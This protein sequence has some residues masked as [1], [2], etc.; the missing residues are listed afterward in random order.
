MAESITVSMPEEL[1]AF[2]RDR[3]RQGVYRSP[4][5]HVRALIREDRRRSA[6]ERLEKLLREGLESG[7]A[8]EID[9]AGWRSHPGRGTRRLSVRDGRRRTL[10]PTRPQRCHRA[11]ALDREGRSGSGAALSRRRTRRE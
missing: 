4:S 8:A 10:A 3:V 11:G 5:E 9:E 7:P 2:V 1:K 6:E